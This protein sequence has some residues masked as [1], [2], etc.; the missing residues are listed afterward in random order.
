M[1][2]PGRD[3]QVQPVRLQVFSVP[4][5]NRFVQLVMQPPLGSAKVCKRNPHVAL[6]LVRRVVDEHNELAP[7]VALPGVSYETVRRPVP[8]PSLNAFQQLPVPIANYG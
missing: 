4:L 1:T 8:L 3:I 5:V 7:L 6:A 2:M